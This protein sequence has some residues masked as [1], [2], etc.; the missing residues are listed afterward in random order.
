MP[1]VAYSPSSSSIPLLSPPDT[2]KVSELTEMKPSSQNKLYSL[3]SDLGNITIQIFNNNK[4][5]MDL[6]VISLSFLYDLTEFLHAHSIFF[7]AAITA[8]SAV[9]PILTSLFLLFFFSHESTL[10]TSSNPSNTLIYYKSFS[11]SLLLSIYKICLLDIYLHT[12]LVSL[13][14]LDILDLSLLSESLSISVNLISTPAITY[15]MFCS[16]FIICFLFYSTYISSNRIFSGNSLKLPSPIAKVTDS[17][18]SKKFPFLEEQEIKKG[19]FVM[20]VFFQA[21]FWYSMYILIENDL[22]VF[23]LNGVIGEILGKEK[24]LKS[25]NIY[26]VSFLE[27]ECS[28]ISLSLTIFYYFFTLFIPMI[29]SIITCFSVCV[30][31]NILKKLIHFLNCFSCLEVLVLG[32]I[33]AIYGIPLLA[34]VA[35][36]DKF[37]VICNFVHSSSE[38]SC[39]DVSVSLLDGFSFLIL[40]TISKLLFVQLFYRV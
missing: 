22:L 2:P 39:L 14:R 15:S 10:F 18:N 25:W 9:L 12:F 4:E 36:T 8:G 24:S 38:L 35:F 31:K 20:S 21:L 34:S 29:L 37:E 28:W 40:A 27:T 23:Q 11:A 6:S 3:S 1:S 17:K 19:Y 32:S 33:V 16:L 13:L 30:N 7:T 26:S 5:I